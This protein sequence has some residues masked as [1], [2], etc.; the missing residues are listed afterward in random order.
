MNIYF[1]PV[2]ANLPSID[3]FLVSREHNMP[4]LFQI[5]VSDTHPVKSHGINAVWEAIPA[6]AKKDGRLLFVVSERS[7][8]NSVQQF[9]TTVA[10]G[11]WENILKQRILRITDEELCSIRGA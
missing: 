6:N 10:K 3:G 2:A 11:A 7:N 4:I 9:T 1:K 8:L 5:T